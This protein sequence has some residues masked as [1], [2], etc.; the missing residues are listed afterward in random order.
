MTTTTPAPAGNLA[1][2]LDGIR[3]S[4]AAEATRK[5]LRGELA[6]AIL[7]L[8]DVLAALLADFKAG[9]LVAPPQAPM[10]RTHRTARAR[11]APNLPP[12]AHRAPRSH[13]CSRR[14]FAPPEPA[15]D[16]PHPPNPC[17]QAADCAAAH[18]R[19]RATREPPATAGAFG[20]SRSADASITRQNQKSKLR[21][22]CRIVTI[23]FRYRNEMYAT[24][25]G[26][27]K[28]AHPA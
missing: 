19:G 16:A 8:L 24:P 13:A 1:L 15:R 7:S 28:P 25:D 17:G 6:A 26:V 18:P 23:S 9:K 2:T 20:H 3:A 14:H 5:G 22:R 10:P 11:Q 12:R 21:K 4:L 27:H